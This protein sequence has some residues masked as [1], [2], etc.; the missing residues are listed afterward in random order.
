MPEGEDLCLKFRPC[1]ETLPDRMEQRGNDREH[2]ILKLSLPPFKFN[3]LNENGGFGRHRAL[4]SRCTIMLM[5]SKGAATVG[6]SG[7]AMD[8]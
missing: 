1:Q 2:S 4:Q 3:W 6:L 5:Q 8:A 7:S